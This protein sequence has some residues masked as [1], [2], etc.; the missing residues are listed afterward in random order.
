MDVAGNT[1]Q[2]A[3]LREA[4]PVRLKRGFLGREIRVDI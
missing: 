3:E 4:D 1:Q 2:Y